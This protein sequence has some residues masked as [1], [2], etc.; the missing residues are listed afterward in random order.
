MIEKLE[1]SENHLIDTTRIA[2]LLCYTK[3]R[4]NLFFKEKELKTIQLDELILYIDELCDIG[5]YS[6]VNIVTSNEVKGHLSIR[7][8]TLFYDFF[9][10]VTDLAIKRS[11]PYII[12]NIGYD[13]EWIKMRILPSFDIGPLKTESKFIEA[14]T[15]ANGKLLRKEI[16]DTVGI[17]ISF[18]KGGLE[19][20]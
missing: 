14:V 8:A 7:Y 4:C 15:N 10:A 17:S 19:N 18:P 9:Y 13:Q 5:K 2:L 20:D 6:N 16:E 1:M 12:V 11:C 3:R